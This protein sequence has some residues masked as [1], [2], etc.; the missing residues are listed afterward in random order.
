MVLARD[1]FGRGKTW[2]C[3]FLGASRSGIFSYK[4]LQRARHCIS[5]ENLL[6]CGG[7][8]AGLTNAVRQLCSAR[9]AGS[10]TPAAPAAG[11]ENLACRRAAAGRRSFAKQMKG[12]CSSF[13]NETCKTNHNYSSLGN[14][15][16]LVK[17]N[18]A[19]LLQRGLGSRPCIFRVSPRAGGR[20]EL[21]S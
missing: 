15:S 8:E 19:P 3:S 14:N 4:T 21:R 18:Q 20:A 9:L 17:T 6:T 16:N 11:S 1:N 13:P 12:K 5:Q 7:A 2:G 10:V